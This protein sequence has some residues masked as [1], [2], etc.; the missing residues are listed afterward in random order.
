MQ[1]ARADG[2]NVIGY[3]CWSINSNREWGLPFGAESDFGLYHIDRDDDPDLKRTETASDAVHDCMVRLPPIRHGAPPL[4]VEEARFFRHLCQG[5]GDLAGEQA[6]VA[7]V[8]VGKGD[9]A[10]LAEGHGH[11]DGRGLLAVPEE[12]QHACPAV[13]LPS[14][15]V[16]IQTCWITP[17]PSTS[18]MVSVS[19]AFGLMKGLTFHRWPRSRAAA[20]KGSPGSRGLGIATPP[21]PFCP[22]G[23]SGEIVR[24]WARVR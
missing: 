13:A 10:V 9:A 12:A 11:F 22:V 14:P 15:S 23:F 8:V 19:P 4:G 7:V 6:K 1:S 16:A 24:V 2:V 18:M 5:I 17:G 21:F 20:E 3:V